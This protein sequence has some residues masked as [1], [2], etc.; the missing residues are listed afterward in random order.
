LALTRGLVKQTALQFARDKRYSYVHIELDDMIQEGYMAVM[1]AAKYFQASKGWQF[2]T[3]AGDCI[4]RRLWRFVNSRAVQPWTQEDWDRESD[5]PLDLIPARGP[6]PL[7]TAMEDLTK[8]LRRL[9]P[10]QRAVVRKRFGLEGTA[11]ASA[12]E[13]RE[14]LG[15]NAYDQRLYCEGL[16]DISA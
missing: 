5:G 2:S 11:A 3:Y 9:P 10:L 4:R 15:V 14:T 6:S 1:D 12:A 16:P 7:E 8:L 13:V